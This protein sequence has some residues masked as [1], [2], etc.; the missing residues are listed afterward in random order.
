MFSNRLISRLQQLTVLQLRTL[1]IKCGI[2]NNGKISKIRLINEHYTTHRI[3]SIDVGIRNL[4][5][6]SMIVPSTINQDFNSISHKNIII[7]EWDKLS[8]EL[9][10]IQ[11]NKVIKKT[12]KP[13]DYS[14]L[15]YQLAKS[16]LEKFKPRTILIERQRYRTLNMNTIHEWIIRVNMFEHMLHAVFRC[17]KEEKIWDDPEADILSIDPTKIISLWTKKN[18]ILKEELFIGHNLPKNIFI[19]SIRENLIYLKPSALKSK[20]IKTK[21]VDSLLKMDT[22]FNF[23]NT[24]ITAKD[25]M[26]Q[27]K[28]KSILKID[29]LADCFLQGVSWII[30]EQNKWKLKEELQDNKPLHGFIND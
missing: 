25:F 26:S 14:F 7:N 12:Y 8:V 1:A 3:L 30:W 6:C 18:I 22:I 10:N 21:I 28:N 20:K 19:N 27:K 13:V 9:E 11:D 15:A 17:F 29:D 5:L 16:F 4:A 24:Q 2:L 23:E